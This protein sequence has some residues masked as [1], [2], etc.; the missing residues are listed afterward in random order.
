MD[1][2][3]TVLLGSLS[4]ALTLPPA[5]S[6]AVEFVDVLD[7]PAVQSALAAQHLLIDVTRAGQRYVA[8]GQRGHILV[9]D[10]DGQS[11]QQAK[12]PLSSDLTAVH[13]P[14]PQQG[15]AVGHDGVVLHSNDGGSTWQRQL[16]GR[17][18]GQLML[19]FY[20]PLA[21]AHPDEATYTLLV[22][23]AHR[24]VA[25]GADK[26]FLD[27]W[28]E[29]PE[30]GYIVGA[31]NLIFH[32][33]DGGRT[34]APLQH[35]IDN[36]YVL[37]LNAIAPSGPDLYIAGEQGLLLK[38][39]RISGHFAALDSP[40]E[41]SFFGLQGSAGGMVMAYG[42][43]GHAF[44][45]TDS[46]LSWLPVR[47]GTSVSLTAS[48]AAA[49]GQLFLFSQAGQA[50]ISKDNGANFQPLQSDRI[51]PI[52]GAVKGEDSLILVGSRGV[53]RVPIQ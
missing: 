23:E 32:T 43:R 31:F 46:G 51:S 24:L 42:L 22:D 26:P 47:T 16:D 39:D 4:L 3:K 13:F 28:F 45:S 1:I 5:T 6:Q 11:W 35:K 50:L 53:R 12:V 41:G 25:E 18:I 17:Q 20:T 48:A 21:Q 33:A 37:H 34:W 14:T 9:S 29:T 40:Y 10:D 38:L 2:R 52:A 49:N 7:K 15:W 27:V 19:D 30:S 8:V 36:P 44:R